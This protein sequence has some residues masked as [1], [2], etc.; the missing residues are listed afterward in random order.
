MP[1]DDP[2]GISCHLEKRIPDVF[3]TRTDSSK[4]Y[5]TSSW[6]GAKELHVVGTFGVASSD[7]RSVDQ[8]GKQMPIEQRLHSLLKPLAELT[9]IALVLGMD[10]Q[11]RKEIDILNVQPTAVTGEQ[12]ATPVF[13]WQLEPDNTIL[14][15]A[16]PLP[17]LEA[18]PKGKS[19]G[20]VN[21]NSMVWVA[22]QCRIP[23]R[24]REAA[25]RFLD[26]VG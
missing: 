23:R 1:A 8:T 18:A 22:R 17:P 24:E 2:A 11:R 16:G 6:E 19:A 10:K 12:I 4:T 21:V 20:S 25:A 7:P 26:T 14:A 15:V 5:A 9:P 3:L 13:E